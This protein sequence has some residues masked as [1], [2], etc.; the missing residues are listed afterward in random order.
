ML[1]RQF[2]YI[3]EEEQEMVLSELHIIQPQL[4]ALIKKYSI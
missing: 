3:T 1:A 2:K 4:N